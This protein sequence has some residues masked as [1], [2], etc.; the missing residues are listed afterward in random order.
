MPINAN[1]CQSMP[2]NARPSP[3]PI[4]CACFLG[5]GKEHELVIMLLRCARKYRTNRRGLKVI[6]TKRSPEPA[7][8]A[9]GHP[10]V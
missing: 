9:K 4:C 7:W 6:E 2:S 3:I 10:V 5:M 8:E 1:Q